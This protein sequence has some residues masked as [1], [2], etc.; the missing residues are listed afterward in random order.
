MQLLTV[1]LSL[2]VGQ[3]QHYSL[4]A[5]IYHHCINSYS[6]S[7]MMKIALRSNWRPPVNK[8][9]VKVQSIHS[10]IWLI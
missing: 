3:L 8:W 7:I 9:L 5:Y 6:S 10:K 4:R 1:K 2:N